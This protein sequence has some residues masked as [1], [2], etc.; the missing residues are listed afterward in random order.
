MLKRKTFNFCSDGENVRLGARRKR[1]RGRE[2]L[3]EKG[4]QRKRSR[5]REELGEKGEQRKR[6]RGRGKGGARRKGRA[7][8]EE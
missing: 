8:E 7:E 4:E 3:G 2:E 6:S 1:S 5:G